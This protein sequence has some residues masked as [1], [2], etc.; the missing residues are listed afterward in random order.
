MSETPDQEQPRAD[1]RVRRGSGRGSQGRVLTYL[2]ILFAAAFFL[3]LMAYFMQ[4]RANRE[5]I[6]GLTESM[7][8]S[9]SSIHS[10]QNLVD[11]NEALEKENDALK[12]E[13]QTLREALARLR[14]EHDALREE[15]EKTSL[16]LD[17]FWQVDEAFVLGRYT[18]CRTLISSMEELDLVKY[19]PPRSATD[20]D[21]AS[22]ADRYRE[23]YDK[24]Y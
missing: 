24:L 2:L 16:A 3:L 10:L 1:R 8:Q 22:P 6:D 18:R 5:T 15:A 4:Q 13:A 20:N 14:E 17:W 9:V 19:L 23:I 21:R 7:N 11:V 12:E